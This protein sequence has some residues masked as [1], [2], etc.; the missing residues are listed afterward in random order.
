MLINGHWRPQT[1]IIRHDLFQ[2]DLVGRAE[3]MGEFFH[4]L[5][6]RLEVKEFPAEVMAKNYVNAQ[7]KVDIAP[8]IEYPGTRQRLRDCYSNDFEVFSYDL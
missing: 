7:P 6:E 5:A 2:P 3:N 1:D 4:K 8:F